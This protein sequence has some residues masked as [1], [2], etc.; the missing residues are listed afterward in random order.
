LQPIEFGADSGG[1]HRIAHKRVPQAHT[2]PSSPR[3]TGSAI[4]IDAPYPF[5]AE[6]KS[7]TEVPA[8]G[9]V[10]G[11]AV[12]EHG[13]EFFEVAAVPGWQEYDF[14]ELRNRGSKSPR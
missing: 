14:L 13:H 7:A 10:C 5:G 8:A 1:P 2:L 6:I 11:P 9:H 4:G 3:R 12:A